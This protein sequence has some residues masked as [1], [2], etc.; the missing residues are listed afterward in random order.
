MHRAV[1]SLFTTAI[2]IAGCGSPLDSP[3][4]GPLLDPLITR[5]IEREL[6][7]VDG[8]ENRVGTT[9]PPSAVEEALAHRM[10]ELDQLVPIPAGSDLDYDLGTD[11]NGDPQG[12][13]PITLQDC[14][15]MALM[16]NLQL[17]NSRL[18]PAIQREQVIQAEAIFDVVLGGG[19]SFT[20]TRTPNQNIAIQGVAPNVDPSIANI[21]TNDAEISLGKQLTS[22]GS[23][24]VSTDLIRSNVQGDDNVTYS[25]NPYWQPS[26]T[27]DYSQPILR[28]FGEKVNLSQVYIA[29]KLEQESIE[30]L[31]QSLI[32]TIAET[33]IAYWNL[34]FSW[35]A[36]GIQLWLID[37]A[38]E[39]RD[40]IDLRRNYD[41]SLADWAQAV[42]IVEQRVAD[43]ISF[44]QA[45]KESSDTLKVLIN[46]PGYPLAGESV[47][48]PVDEMVHTP[49][50]LDLRSTLLT[51]IAK[52]PDVR[53]SVLQIDIARIEEVVADNGRLP[54]LDLQAQIGTTGMSDD[55]GQSYDR[56]FDGD[57]IS[58][59]LG[60]AFQY[61]LGNRAAEAA[62]RESRLG[63]SSAMLAYR[64]SIQ[65]AILD[66]KTSMREV[67]DNAEYIN[68]TRVARLATAEYLRA[69]EVE[70]ETLAS[71]TPTFLN[72]IF[73]A[74]A[75]LATAR[76][77]EFQAI[78]SFNTSVVQLH[79]A[80]GT[81]LDM[82][83][84]GLQQID[85]DAYWGSVLEPTDP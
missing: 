57:F 63:R 50:S 65:Q 64:S 36:L 74:Q 55:F 5:V 10:D 43:V 47:L 28:G 40:I 72:L 79:R 75:S 7:E 14:V 8:L 44:Q 6:E 56:T 1:P 81:V 16:N 4:A 26:L 77:D 46:D 2:L 67:I 27:L 78:S 21:R 66:V 62:W 30:S 11:L 17:Q 38:V 83:Q 54:E 51:A 52:R 48:A 22:G 42:S 84:I 34:A 61:P 31:R 12:Q 23:V 71:L 58:Y 37:A 3:D 70:R 9:P 18:Q 39:L 41:A 45:V 76:S 13:R 85:E 15:R 19:Y 32:D 60:L 69:L 35:R 24:Q 68:A 59:V 73:S 20:R 80:M 25:P 49:L 53:K 82:H 29:R 33:E